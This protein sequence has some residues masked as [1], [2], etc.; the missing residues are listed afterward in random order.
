MLPIFLR[1]DLANRLIKAAVQKEIALWKWPYNGE[2]HTYAQYI[3]LNRVYPYQD[4]NQLLE[5]V[6]YLVEKREPFVVA[7]M[8]IYTNGTFPAMQKFCEILRYAQ[9][10]GGTVY[11]GL[12]H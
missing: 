3:V 5:I 9:D 4:P 2:P 7:V 11:N 8:P 1:P 12:P 10:N 6:N